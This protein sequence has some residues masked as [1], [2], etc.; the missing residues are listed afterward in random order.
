MPA[1]LSP[2]ES[3]PVRT[4]PVAPTLG[5]PATVET[6]VDPVTGASAA[7]DALGLLYRAM[8]PGQE[9]SEVVLLAER[10]GQSTDVGDPRTWFEVPG[11]KI[12]GPLEISASKADGSPALFPVLGVVAV[13]GVAHDDMGWVDPEQP[14]L[15]RAGALPYVVARVVSASELGTAVVDAAA[16][17]PY[18]GLLDPG[19]G[20]RVVR[21]R[22]VPQ[23]PALLWSRDEPGRLRASRTSPVPSL[24][25]GGGPQDLGGAEAGKLYRLVPPPSGWPVGRLLP[26]DP[27]LPDAPTLLRVGGAGAGSA[28]VGPVLA[29]AAGVVVPGLDFGSLPVVAAVVEPDTGRM[30]LRPGAVPA[31]ARLWHS[32]LAFSPGGTGEV[33]PQG[34]AYYLSPAPEPGEL[35][36]LR[37]GERVPLQVT[38]VAT[39]QELLSTPDP[40]PG[41]AV[42]AGSTGRV[43]LSAAERGQLGGGDPLYYQGVFLGRAAPATAQMLLPRSGLTRFA[44]GGSA[45]SGEAGALQSLLT[46]PSTLS[47]RV[48]TPAV[49]FPKSAPLA[50]SEVD[51]DAMLPAAAPPGTAVFSRQSR[52]LVL[53]AGTDPAE[54]GWVTTSTA[55]LR[56]F[57]AGPRLR[58]M[59]RHTFTLSG[60]ERFFL[61]AAPRIPFIW[62]AGSLG[63]GTYSAE[64]VAASLNRALDP[65]AARCWVDRGVLVIEAAGDWVEVLWGPDPARPDL[66][67][68]AALGFCPG[69]RAT[70]SGA[71][72]VDLG[73]AVGLPGDGVAV[74]RRFAGILRGAQDAL[75]VVILRDK[76][77]QG[78]P[79]LGDGTALWVRRGGDS[80]PVRVGSDVVYDA[81]GGRLLWATEEVAQVAAKFPVISVNLGGALPG[82]VE[83][84]V[85]ESGRWVPLSRGT[86]YDLDP[87]GLSEVRLLEAVG[88]RRCAGTGLL[89][90]NP[91]RLL[92]PDI[93][94]ACVLPGAR[95]QV[96][97]QWY[98]A[99]GARP[100]QVDLDRAPPADGVGEPAAYQVVAPAQGPLDPSVVADA[101]LVPVP[102]RTDSDLRAWVELPG[103][104]P[105]EL[106]SGVDFVLDPLSGLVALGGPLPPGASV[107]AR[108]YGATAAGRRV[109]EVVDAQVL[110]STNLATARKLG[111]TD[112]VFGES[113][114]EPARDQA[115][116]VRVAEVSGSVARPDARV[117]YPPALAPAGRVVFPAELPPPTARVEV[118][119]R[120]RQAAGG[121]RLLDLG[122]AP[123]YATY[124]PVPAGQPF[125]G[126]RGDRTQEFEGGQLLR[127]GA[128]CFWVLGA[129]YYPARPG[130]GDATRI[131]VSPTPEAAVGSSGPADPVLLMRSDRPL[132]GAPGAWVPADLAGPLAPGTSQVLLRGAPPGGVVRAGCVLEVGGDPYFVVAVGEADELG[133]VPATLSSALLASS[134]ASKIGARVTSRPLYPPDPT[135][136]SGTR[137]FPN[138]FSE[139][140]LWPARGPG[141]SLVP[142]VEVAAGA[143]GAV[144]LLGGLSLRAGESLEVFGQALAL[145]V[146]DAQGRWPS[147]RVRVLRQVAP[148]LLPGDVV[149]GSYLYLAADGMRFSVEDPPLFRVLTREDRTRFAELEDLA[150]AQRV[151]SFLR[152]SAALAAAVHGPLG[153]QVGG[154]DGP[155]P[156]PLE[157]GDEWDVAMRRPRRPEPRL[158]DRVAPR[159]ARVRFALEAHPEVDPS[160]GWVF[161]GKLG[162][163]GILRA[164]A[165]V[166]PEVSDLLGI[167][168]QGTPA[169]QLS[170]PPSPEAVGKPLFL[171][172]RGLGF[173]PLLDLPG[174]PAAWSEGV[175]DPCR[176]ELGA[177]SAAGVRAGDLPLW[178]ARVCSGDQVAFGTGTPLGMGV[179]VDV[180]EDGAVLVPRG[181]RLAPGDLVELDLHLARPAVRELP[182]AFGQARSDAGVED[183]AA[184][185]PAI[186]AR[187]LAVRETRSAQRSPESEGGV[188]VASGTATLRPGRILD[189]EEYPTSRRLQPGDLLSGG[190]RVA[191]VRAT[192]FD[193]CWAEF[194]TCVGEGGAAPL[195]FPVFAEA[196]AD[197]IVVEGKPDTFS[198]S[199]RAFLVLDPAAGGSANPRSYGKMLLGF[200]YGALRELGPGLFG[201]ADPSRFSFA[202]GS[203]ADLEAARQAGPVPVAGASWLPLNL[204]L[205]HGFGWPG[206]LRWVRLRNPATGGQVHLDLLGRQ[207]WVGLAHAD[208]S[209]CGGGRCAHPGSPVRVELKLADAAWRDLNNPRRHG[210]AA[211]DARC[212]LP[213]TEVELDLAPSVGVLLDEYGD[214]DVPEA[215]PF[216]FGADRVWAHS[217]EA[218][219][220]ELGELPRPAPHSVGPD[221]RRVGDA[222][223]EAAA[224]LEEVGL[225]WDR[226]GHLISRLLEGPGVPA[227]DEVAGALA[228]RQE[229][230]ARMA[231]CLEHVVR[232]GGAY[233]AAVAAALQDRYDPARGTLE[234]LRRIREE[235]P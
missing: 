215:V 216:A 66:T 30:M 53:P 24:L 98:L 116:E 207:G 110:V 94:P 26:G 36:L 44:P 204:D 113:G 91:P 80:I 127:V 188:R 135:E 49:V 107:R 184:P 128:S 178:R 99:V 228:Q 167:H 173:R 164:R 62:D 85:L 96:G 202:D 196:R 67:G 224:L 195:E 175:A 70:R 106:R 25:P 6:V 232:Q 54:Q 104:E 223:A 47:D 221:L 51:L 230:A 213:G 131:D 28:P 159:R 121:E 79:G 95:I 165:W 48:G 183:A 23:P 231:E 9:V 234:K 118:R 182:A 20:D 37:V 42:V 140:V 130:G 141:R 87:S 225:G 68:C 3:F 115:A 211:F 199:G 58:S 177:R 114:P 74:A 151:S 97:S 61:A 38:W 76:P 192:R 101:T 144:R 170:T 201:F 190:G 205:G 125:V 19:R 194:R 197:C 40:A 208:G 65:A 145:L 46:P 174:S 169:L 84:A 90:G 4:G 160:S 117:D 162:L 109:G 33:L 152:I 219:R 172:L 102:Y 50:V 29:V 11:G 69:W 163:S 82:S 2:L 93:D 103:Q 105:R 75:P 189:Y 43:L 200:S 126:L 139:V 156:P 92:D 22:C 186:L 168:A 119:Y 124:V 123:A 227:L 60:A 59:L 179:D 138:G 52:Q 210:G 81:V 12:L 155:L 78:G 181:G 18:G 14:G 1:K 13:G 132:R 150:A 73:A 83:V 142:G 220:R 63:A 45:M 16:L 185:E 8:A 88:P 112:Y 187:V 166:G 10:S 137:V 233:R 147:V 134:V 39:E 146:P 198:P 235:L 64:V 111:A 217:F 218:L 7:I 212:L 206:T 143:R 17:E 157:E 153:R 32:A 203:R 71:L 120:S 108:F 72:L 222:G 122:A 41:R 56:R 21:V 209:R 77:A 148:D 229:H 161:A 158:E 136:L 180:E 57:W 129:R 100:G 133:Q 55:M 226:L 176:I 191:R 35:P 171:R 214:P 193:G 15:G 86:G 34:G 89:A 31:G 27:G 149:E 154:A 5:V